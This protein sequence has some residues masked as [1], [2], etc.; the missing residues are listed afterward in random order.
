MLSILILDCSNHANADRFLQHV[1]VLSVFIV[2]VSILQ[3]MSLLAVFG[4][5]ELAIDILFV[6]VVLYCISFGDY[7]NFCCAIAVLM[8]L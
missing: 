2:C 3:T 6:F 4:R 8:L 1:V 5:H 7:G